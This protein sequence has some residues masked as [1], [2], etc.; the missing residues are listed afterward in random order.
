MAARGIVMRHI[1]IIP[2]RNEESNIRT[3][4][5]SID[6][7]SKV[8]DRVYVV[9]DGSSDSTP[10]IVTAIAKER[11]YIHLLRKTDCGK[12]QMGGGVVDTFNVA[13]AKCRAENFTYISKIDADIVLPPNYFETL[14]KFMDE[15]PRMGAASGVI[16]EQIGSRMVRLR[17]PKNHVPGALKTIRKRVFEEMGGFLPVLGWDVIDLVKIRSVGYG[18]VHFNDLRVVHLRQHAS[19]EGLLRGKAQ[20]GIGAYV[21]GSHP[22]FVF[23]RGLY[24]M[25]EHPYVIGG[26]AFWWGYL[27]AAAK[28]VTKISDNALIKCLRKEQ[29]QRMVF[30]NRLPRKS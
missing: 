19:A 9:D 4:L 8:P 3:T 30:L 15:H 10:E 28:K 24:R 14:L 18:N 29:L 7:Q 17:L 25:L 20:W 26:L 23:G 12:R 22:L 6:S 27:S 16:Y 21:I 13:Y 1:V 5:D 11:R 2:A